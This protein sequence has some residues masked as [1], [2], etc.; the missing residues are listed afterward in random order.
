L[1]KITVKVPVRPLEKAQEASGQ[2]EMN[3]LSLDLK[4]SCGESV[5]F[6]FLREGRVFFNESFN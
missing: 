3:Y 1:R 4:P 5:C 2:G 6:L